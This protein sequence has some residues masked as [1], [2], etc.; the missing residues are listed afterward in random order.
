[1]LKFTVLSLTLAVLAAAIQGCA[2][3]AEDPARATA[4][5]LDQVDQH[6]RE[7]EQ[8]MIDYSYAQRSDFSKRMQAN[9]DAINRDLDQLSVSLA[10]S[11]ETVKTESRPRME[12]LRA[13]SA[14]LK[15]Q[16]DEVNQANEST[17]AEV[18]IAIKKGYGNL[19]QGFN[20][21]RQWTSDKIA[22]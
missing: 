5:R 13:Q 2:P 9:L 14:T 8:E 7:A 4:A 12:A 20:D 16:L 19:K 1:M 17:W 18:K 6:T 11:S 21:A 15:Q 10:S 3:K 22:P